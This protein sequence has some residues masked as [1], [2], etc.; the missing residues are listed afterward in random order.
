LT[1]RSEDRVIGGTTEQLVLTETAV[2]A[3]VTVSAT[4]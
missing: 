2:Y 1:V 3:V 4:Y